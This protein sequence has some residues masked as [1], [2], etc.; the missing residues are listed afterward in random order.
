MDRH[1]ASVLGDVASDWRKKFAFFAG[2]ALQSFA[3]R[4]HSRNLQQD[5]AQFAKSLRKP[6]KPV[7]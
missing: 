1:R 5:E 4:V 7:V 3:N 2:V 6:Q